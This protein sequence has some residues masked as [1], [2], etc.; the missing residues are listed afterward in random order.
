MA[1][2]KEDTMI[3]GGRFLARAEQ[4]EK[5][6]NAELTFGARTGKHLYQSSVFRLLRTIYTYS[7]KTPVFGLRF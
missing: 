2:Y 3:Q 4:L 5:L 1:L 7:E 6:D